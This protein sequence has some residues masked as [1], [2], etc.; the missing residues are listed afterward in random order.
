[1]DS[2]LAVIVVVTV[3]EVNQRK[4]KPGPNPMIP[5]TRPNPSCP[6]Q[7]D[8]KTSSCNEQPKMTS[9][10]RGGVVLMRYK[11]K[12]RGEARGGGKIGMNGK[13]GILG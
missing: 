10:T 2:E 1:M 5:V 3:R 6:D 11:R 4:N 13:M 8:D 12:E 7:V 9:T